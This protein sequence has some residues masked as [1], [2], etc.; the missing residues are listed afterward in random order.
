MLRRLPKV[1]YSSDPP[2]Y[3]ENTGSVRDALGVPLP[4]SEPAWKDQH[5]GLGFFPSYVNFEPGRQFAAKLNFSSAKFSQSAIGMP[6]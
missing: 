2:L 6:G 4:I 3:Q 1:A 5:I